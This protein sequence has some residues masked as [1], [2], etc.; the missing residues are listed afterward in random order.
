MADFWVSQ[1]RHWC[2]YCKK[3]IAN[4]K[5]SLDIH[6]NGRQ[7]K[8]AV[9]RFLRG[10][11][12]DGQVKKEED[13]KKLK[14]LQR[15]EKA[16]MMSMG[17]VPSG[18]RSSIA[19]TTKTRPSTKPSI[20]FA[21]PPPHE[22]TDETQPPPNPYNLQGRDEWAVHT[23]TA[24][25]GEWQT[26][27]SK[28]RKAVAAESTDKEKKGTTHDVAPEFQDDEG[29]DEEDLAN[30]KI[31]EKQ[32]P[33]DDAAEDDKTEAPVFKKRKIGQQGNKAKRRIRSK[34]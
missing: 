22:P 33:L 17:G 27:A 4:N 21:P 8:D 11:Y 2:K 16:A 14:E 3:Y 5:P 10:V 30:F 12:K 23:D 34:D 7:H 18:Y 24:T 19:T 13:E 15:I 32:L 28:P 6:N 29:E 1:Q 31:Q 20:T 25:P 9:E 26:V